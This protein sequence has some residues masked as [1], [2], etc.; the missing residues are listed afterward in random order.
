[1]AQH[2]DPASAAGDHDLIRV[3]K[4]PDGVYLHDILGLGGRHDP[5][6]ALS[7]LFHHEIAFF[8]LCGRFLRSHIAADYFDWLRKRVVIGIYHYLRDNRAH[9]L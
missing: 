7:F 6:E 5:A 3:Q 2:R 1:M 4:R 8:L 9:R